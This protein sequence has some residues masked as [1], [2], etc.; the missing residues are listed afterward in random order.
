MARTNSTAIRWIVAVLGLLIGLCVYTYGMFH[1]LIPT[2]PDITAVANC[3]NVP[4]IRTYDAVSATSNIEEQDSTLCQVTP[5]KWKK[6]AYG[7]RP[8]FLALAI[9]LVSVLV[10]LHRSPVLLRATRSV[11]GCVTLCLILF[12]T[13]MTLLGLHLNYIEGTLT[14]DWALHVV[15][16][17]EA[18]GALVGLPMWYAVVQPAQ[19]RRARRL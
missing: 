2:W 8:F 3:D 10:A 17:A 18:I 11:W 15:L 9:A 7:S 14:P 5:G 6:S 4:G 1:T 19:A 16:Y 13:P 12:G